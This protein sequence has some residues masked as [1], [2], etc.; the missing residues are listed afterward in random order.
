MKM[1]KGYNW[2]IKINVLD[3]EKIKELNQRMMESFGSLE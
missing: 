3:V 1:S 2:E